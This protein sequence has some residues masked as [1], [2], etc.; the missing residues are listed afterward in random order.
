MLLI[1]KQ[2]IL[3]LQELLSIPERSGLRSW[4]L[5]AATEDGALRQV[6]PGAGSHG[7]IVV[8]SLFGRSRSTYERKVVQ[9][10][11]GEASVWGG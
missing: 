1:W 11:F 3:L 9:A 6:S 5:E 8:T 4:G 7:G 2:N 10:R